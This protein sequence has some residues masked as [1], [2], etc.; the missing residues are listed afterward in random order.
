MGRQLFVHWT[1]QYF[2]LYQN[3][4]HSPAA[5]CLQH[6]DQRINR[7]IPENWEHYLVQ[8]R[9]EVTSMHAGNR[10]WQ[11]MTTKPRDTVNQQT[12]DEQGR[13]NAMH[14]CLGTAFHSK[15]IGFG[16]TCA[17]TFLWKER[18]LRFGRWCFKSGDIKKT[19]ALCSC[20][21]PQKTKEMFSANSKV[22]WFDN[23]RAQW[24]QRRTWISEQSPIRSRGTSSRHSVESES[25]Q[26]FTGDEKNSQ[27]FSEIVAECNSY[28]YRQ[29]ISMRQAL[30]RIIMESSNNYTSSIGYK[31]NCRT[32]CTSSK[33]RE[34]CR[35]V[36]IWIGW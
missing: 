12:R 16:D 28:S 9:F 1:I 21:L 8:Y 7:I 14:S 36:A 13:S 11:I 18:E 29:F 27:K 26:S 33:R 34:I 19:E 17:R 24:I 23:S 5:V 35:I 32:S 10:C 2:S 31:R 20:L 25:S 15:S 6:R 3:C 30:W 22:W 4:H